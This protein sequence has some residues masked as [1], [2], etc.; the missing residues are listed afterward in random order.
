MPNKSLISRSLIEELL[1]VEGH[2]LNEY[3][4]AQY[5]TRVDGNWNWYSRAAPPRVVSSEP[6]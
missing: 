4:H 2:A 6:S 1:V 5:K 3:A